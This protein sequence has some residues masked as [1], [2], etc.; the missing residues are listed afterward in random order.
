MKGVL[1]NGWVGLVMVMLFLAN[2]NCFSQIYAPEGLNMPGAWNGWTNPP[3]NNLAIASSTQVTNGRVTKITTGTARYQTIFSVAAS[4]ADFTGGTYAWAFTSGPSGNPWNTK[5]GGAGTVALNSL[6]NYTIAGADN[7]ITLTNGKWYTMNW[8]DIGYVNTTAI[9]METSATPVDVTSVTQTPLAANVFPTQSVTINITT[10]ATPASEEKIYVRYSTDD[11]S[12]SDLIQAS[13][14][15]T[16]GTA[17]IPASVGTVKYYVFSTTANSPSSDFDLYTIKLNNNSDAN[18]SYTVASSWITA[19]DGNWSATTTWQGG[20]VPPPSLGVPVTIA[21]NVTLDQDVIVGSLTINSGKTFTASD[22]FA[23]N[24]TDSNDVSGTTLTNNGIWANGSGG[25]TV[26]FSGNAV[27]TVSGVIGFNNV[28]INTAVN[29]G[30]ASMVTNNFQINANGS[31]HTNAPFYGSSS[32]LIYNTGSEFFAA[33]EW[34]ANYISGQG[35]PQNVQIG[36]SA[37]NNSKLSFTDNTFW[38]QCNGNLTIG[39]SA[40]SGYSLILS[41]KAGGDVKVCGN[42]N[43]YPNGSFTPNGR[44]VWLAGS[45]PQT[46][47]VTGGGTE[48]FSYLIV[49][50]PVAVQLSNAGSSLTDV[51]IDGNNSGTG[52]QLQLLADGVLDLQ[53]RTLYMAG[54]PGGNINVS[55]GI[56]HIAGSTGSTLKI[57]SS[58]TITSTSGGTLVTDAGVVVEIANA[59]ASATDFNVGAG[60]TTINGTLRL[61]YGYKITNSPAYGT[62]S[63]LQYNCTGAPPRGPEWMTAVGFGYPNDVQISNNTALDP[64]GASLTG[65]ALNLAGDLTIDAGSSIYMDYG[66][67]DMTVPLV[68]GRNLSLAGNLFLSDA[69]GGD[70]KVGGNWTHS[71]GTFAP[72]GRAVFFNGATG[73]QTISNAGIETFDYVIV[74]KTTS[75]NVTLANDIN[76]NQTLTLTKGLVST[77]S[78]KVTITSTGSIAA[79]ASAIS[80]IDGILAQTYNAAGSK[81][82]PIGKGG[83]YR[84]LSFNY[85]SLTGTSVVTTEQIESALSG[86]LPA[87]KALLGNRYWSISESGGSGFNY[88]V[89]LDATGLPTPGTVFMLKKE[90]GSIT[91]DLTTSNPP[92]YTN[93]NGF[94]TLTGVN[95]FTLALDCSGVTSIAGSNQEICVGAS[96][97][98]AANTPSSGTGTWAVVSGPSTSSGQFS[99]VGNPSATF[100]PAGGDGTYVLSWT[101]SYSTCPPA[102]S[103]VTITVHAKPTPSAIY[104]D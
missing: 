71:T 60:L 93:S 43:R 17:T 58:K 49:D 55:G 90:S 62:S 32:T 88:N 78:N 24:L 97:V 16:A 34:Y 7:S 101:V 10:S 22:G 75:G 67:N 12:S 86:T 77:G 21:H 96:A 104:H 61:N 51:S 40:G 57:Q 94:T 59:V 31:V 38:R 15:G 41:T 89:T 85:T 84:P 103:N 50:N 69:I 91:S 102:T 46:I 14:T 29:F 4:G 99:A 73:D 28:I 27:H 8:K 13:F 11:F 3:T 64:G 87:N 45:A 1:K 72:K 23:R 95:D 98:M 52:D 83:N 20:V 74:D 56:R 92:N 76:V 37:V 79:G 66:S 5:W 33:T 6:Q 36:T 47:S 53:G 9:F 70:I 42:W 30:S 82:F 44:A 68:V 100:T 54:T 25:S 65:T 18:Y 48:V 39:A 26:T 81:A 63:L 2:Q 19:Q 35:V 80:Y